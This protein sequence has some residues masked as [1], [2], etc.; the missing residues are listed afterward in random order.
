MLRRCAMHSELWIATSFPAL[1]TSPLIPSTP[2]ARRGGRPR[3]NA[4]WTVAAR[5]LARIPLPTFTSR[6]CAAMTVSMRKMSAGKGYEYLLRSVVAGDGNRALTTPLTRYYAEAGT[7]PGCWIGTGLAEFGDGQIVKGSVVTQS[8]LALLLGMG[9]DPVTG[10]QLGLAYQEFPTVP[11]RIAKRIEGIEPG[12]ADGDREAAITKIEKEENKKGPRSA[13][14]GFD[15]TFSVPKSVS[16]LWGVVDAGTQALIVEAHHEAVAPVV[17]F[18]EREVAL[19]RAGSNARNG[20][21]AQHEILGIAA[22]AYDHWDSRAGDPQLHT[23]VVISNKVRTA[24]DRKWRSLDSIP[25]HRCVVAISEHYNAVLADTL[26]RTFGVEWDRRE[27]GKDRTRALEVTGVPEELVSEFSSRSRAIDIETDSLI[28]KYVADH[29]RRPS[30]RVIIELRAA[31]TLSTR[32]EKHVH[33][34]ADLTAGWRNRASRLLRA[35]ATQWARTITSNKAGPMLRADDVPLDLIAE[36]GSSVVEQ[37]SEK[38]STWRHWNLWA[39]ASRQTMEWRF[40]SVQDREAVVGMVVEAATRASLSLTPPE[41]A[42]SPAAF[43][44]EDGSSRFRPRHSTVFSSAGLLAA[45]D[46]LLA[47]ANNSEAATVDLEVVEEVTSREVLGH[48]LLSLIHI[49]E[50]TRRTPI[51]YAV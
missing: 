18:L 22:A 15:F 38:R 51:S 42:V 1:W 34:L 50:P 47:R 26:T 33:S 31:A 40:A 13:V 3:I 45:E 48:I 27:R 5:M 11:Q 25:L 28:E 46:R 32:E 12:P 10:D 29:G 16:V 19:T 17:A 7:P 36:V 24:Y 6:R 41:L 4:A 35:D 37:V 23:H 43:R 21:V 30:K 8:Q 2:L 49:S 14:A 44:R 39:E 9:R 20:A